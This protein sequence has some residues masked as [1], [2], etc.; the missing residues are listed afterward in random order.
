MWDK[1][2]VYYNTILDRNLKKLEDI[3]NTPT[4]IT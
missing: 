4:I 2:I 3:K 1:N